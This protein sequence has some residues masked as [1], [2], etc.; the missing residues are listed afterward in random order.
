MGVYVLQFQ[1]FVYRNLKPIKVLATGFLNTSGTDESASA[2]ITYPGGKTALVATSARVELPN[3]GVI[4]GTK[5]IIRVPQFWC[6]TE[7]I[8]PQKHY[9]FDLPKTSY[10][11]NFN[12]SVGLSYEAEHARQLIKTGIFFLLY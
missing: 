10:R 9:K 7:L 1:Q 8:T 12:N 3:E 2:I 6:P 11:Y 5:G 4:V